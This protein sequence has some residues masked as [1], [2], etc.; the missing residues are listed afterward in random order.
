VKKLPVGS[1]FLDPN[2]PRFW[3]E[4]N[5]RQVPDKRIPDEKVQS[6]AGW[7]VPPGEAMV[8]EG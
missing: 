5:I 1:I 4:Q 2:N 6:E 7:R 3:T 8:A